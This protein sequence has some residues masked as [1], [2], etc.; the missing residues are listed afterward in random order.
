MTKEKAQVEDS[1][2]AVCPFACPGWAAILIHQVENGEKLEHGS[3]RVA[4]RGKSSHGLAKS[5]P[6]KLFLRSITGC[7]KLK[8]GTGEHVATL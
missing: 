4:L 1:R 2:I 5:L 6:V 7:S 8:R 3:A